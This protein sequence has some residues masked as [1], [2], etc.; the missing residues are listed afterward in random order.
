LRVG[1]PKRRGSIPPQKQEEIRPESG[2]KMRPFGNG[3]FDGKTI[4]TSWTMALILSAAFFNGVGMASD[5]DP[6]W[7]PENLRR[8]LFVAR[9]TM[10]VLLAAL[11]FETVR[12]GV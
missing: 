3:H 1:R 5:Q 7:T 11:A 12:F 4:M 6:N 8:S 9:M 2:G 10:F